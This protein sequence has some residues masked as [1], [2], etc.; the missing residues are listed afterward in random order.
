LALAQIGKVDEAIADAQTVLKVRPDDVMMYRNLG[1]FL[2]RK[3]QTA[4]AI[5]A[6]KAGLQIDPNNENL[7]QLIEEDLKALSS[8]NSK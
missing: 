6:F 4:A 8:S 5:E 7:R 3:G 1:L 2:D